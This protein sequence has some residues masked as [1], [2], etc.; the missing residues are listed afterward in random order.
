LR[1]DVKRER[2]RGLVPFDS[3][4]TKVDRGA[5]VITIDPPLGL[6]DD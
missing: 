3:I 1:L 4:V 5:R 6:L 2:G